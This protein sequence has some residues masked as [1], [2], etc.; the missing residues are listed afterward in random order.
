MHTPGEVSAMT[1]VA[2][3]KQEQSG[4]RKIKYDTTQQ[5]LQTIQLK[6]ITHM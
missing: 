3:G 6:E 2:K 1:D 5:A 4:V